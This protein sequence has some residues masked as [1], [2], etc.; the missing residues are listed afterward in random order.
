RGNRLFELG[1]GEVALAFT[2][3][4]SKADQLAIDAITGTHGCADFAAR[5][6]RHRGLGWAAE[7]LPAPSPLP[8]PGPQPG[9]LPDQPQE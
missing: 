2:A 4:S 5:W 7:L 3:T 8:Q 9:L 6:L 1:L